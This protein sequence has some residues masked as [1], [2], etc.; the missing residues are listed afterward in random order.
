MF[1]KLCERLEIV[2]ILMRRYGISGTWVGIT[3]DLVII[4]LLIRWIATWSCRETDGNN[5][6]HSAECLHK[7]VRV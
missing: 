7:W 3:A 6:I 5:C 2:D 1:L 4:L